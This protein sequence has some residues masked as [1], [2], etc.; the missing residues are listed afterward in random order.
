[1]HYT[2]DGDPYTLHTVHYT[3][4]GCTGGAQATPP[5]VPPRRP[6]AERAGSASASESDQSIAEAPPPLASL[7]RLAGYGRAGYQGDSGVID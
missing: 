3:P 4:D 6:S 2:P 1:M 7:Q 5:A